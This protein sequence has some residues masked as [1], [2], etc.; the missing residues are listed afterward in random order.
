MPLRWS[1]LSIVLHF[2]FS[3]SAS[4]IP[5]SLVIT[6]LVHLLLNPI[7]PSVL[8]SFT[9]ASSL[10]R[11]FN[12][13]PSYSPS[14]QLLAHI[15]NEIK[16]RTILLDE[17]SLLFHYSPPVTLH[18]SLHQIQRN[19]KICAMVEAK[20][21]IVSKF[22]YTDTTGGLSLLSSFSYKYFPHSCKLVHTLSYSHFSHPSAIYQTPLKGPYWVVTLQT[23]KPKW[24]Y[25]HE[26]K[27]Q[28]VECFTSI[29]SSSHGNKDKS[30]SLSEE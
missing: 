25:T 18:L 13:F 11:F 15:P 20:V 14:F 10:D 7:S 22:S 3:D 26:I 30:M 16:A 21:E 6:T 1:I 5:S 4:Y 24:K 28:L 9:R 8:W 23:G 12:T 19:S 27:T 17:N 29:K 2:A